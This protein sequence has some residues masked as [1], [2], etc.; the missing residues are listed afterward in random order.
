MCRNLTNFSFNITL[1]IQCSMRN[2]RYLALSL[3]HDVS[4]L[5]DEIVY[6]RLQK[7]V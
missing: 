2:T 1:Y 5:N 4:K 3:C 6:S 7:I